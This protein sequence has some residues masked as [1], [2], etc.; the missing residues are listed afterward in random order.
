MQSDNLE[1]IGG[2]GSQQVSIVVWNGEVAKR[3][4]RRG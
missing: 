1:S 2:G 4:K 3:M